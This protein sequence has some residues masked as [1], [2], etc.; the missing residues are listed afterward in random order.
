MKEEIKTVEQRSDGGV[1]GELGGRGE[2]EGVHGVVRNIFCVSI[3]GQNFF[4]PVPCDQNGSHTAPFLL[5]MPL[6]CSKSHKI[7]FFGIRART[8]LANKGVEP[9]HLKFLLKN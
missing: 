1:C 5:M 9:S 2:G 8:E 3:F 6:K 7:G 4:R